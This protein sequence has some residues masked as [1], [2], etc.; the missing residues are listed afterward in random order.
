MITLEGRVISEGITPTFLTGL[1]AVFAIYYIFNLQ[2]QEEAACTLEFI[3][4]RF[5]G[6]NPERG[7]KAI[8]GKVVSKKTAVIVQK[9][10][11]LPHYA[12]RHFVATLRGTRTSKVWS[13]LPEPEDSSF[14]QNCPHPPRIF[15][16][17]L[18]GLAGGCLKRGAGTFTGRTEKVKLRGGRAN[19]KQ[20]SGWIDEEATARRGSTV[21]ALLH[22]DLLYG[23]QTLIDGSGQCASE[24]DTLRTIGRRTPSLQLLSADQ[25]PGSLSIETRCA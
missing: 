10:L 12:T 21:E 8:L 4:R 20:G 15:L 13:S 18:R 19:G 14:Y 23:C 7:T 16:K 5:I 2:Y 25:I 17:G 6:I 11:T 22:G 1:V 24:S 3:Q 9:K